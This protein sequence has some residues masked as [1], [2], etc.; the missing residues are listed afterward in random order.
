MLRQH[1][2]HTEYVRSLA[3]LNVLIG[4]KATSAALR[5]LVG[6]PRRQGWSWRY[7][8]LADIMADGIP[9]GQT[10]SVAHMRRSFERMGHVPLPSDVTITPVREADLRGEWVRAR[11]C[12]DNAAWLYLHGGAYVSGSL[13]TH[14]FLVAELS[15]QAHTPILTIDYRLA[16]EFPYPAA[17]VDAWSAYWHLLAAGFEPSRIIVGGD[18]AGGGLTI[19]LMLALRDAGLPLPAAGVCL[20]PWTDLALTGR[21]LVSNHDFDYLKLPSI[22]EVV[23]LILGD[24]DPRRS[25]ASPIYA[26]LRGLP[27]LLIQSGTAEM[28]Y[29]DAAR[30]ARRAS[31]AG[32][33]VQFEPWENMVHVWHFLFAVEPAARDA[34]A[35]IGRFVRQQVKEG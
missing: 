34:I 5:R 17:L 29:D 23:P 25:T 6:R 9:E 2:S 18:S 10:A 1:Q 11:G 12:R 8:W 22:R 28:L 24:A 27:P 20:S 35:S 32:V 26:D 13:A 15:R 21:T 33:R 30:L 19:A 7:E 16:P 3:T 14:R 31:E 4:K